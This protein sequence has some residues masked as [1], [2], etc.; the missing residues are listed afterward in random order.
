M[1]K[2]LLAP[3]KY[4][5]GTAILSDAYRY[6]AHIGRNFVII[7]D[8][9]VTDI[10][11]NR[12]NTGFKN[13]GS[14]CRFMRFNGESTL[15]EVKRLASKVS[16]EEGCDGIIGAGGGKTLD[17]AKLVGNMCGLPVVSVPT[18]ASNDSACSC[19]ASIY[20]ESGSFQ[21]IERV[22]ENP[23]VVL[24][25]TEIISKAPMRFFIAGMGEAFSTYYSARACYRSGVPNYTGGERTYT[26]LSISKTCRDVL[27]R[28]GVQALEDMKA[29]RISE[30]IER[31]I[32][33]NIYLSGVGY[34]NNGCAASHAVHNALTIA[35][36]PFGS[37]HGEGTA[38]GVLVQLIM[39]YYEVGQWDHDEWNCIINFYRDIGLP[40]NYAHLKIAEP[41][42]AF[43]SRV[44]EAACLKNSNIHNMPFKV[45]EKKVY[46]ALKTL[47]DMDID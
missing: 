18:I 29:R 5:Q 11:S 1:V 13:A 22:K 42:G 21:K 17:T 30:P 31:I 40:R 12:I 7:A 35:V 28:Y 19:M 38:F 8:D 26:A 4:Y 2:S 20:S 23:K 41:D 34:E 9:K 47:R 46:D 24:V 37:M 10:I 45:T 16:N 44:A 25:D 15:K 27:L 33:A 6:V 3:A 43:L 39:E 14:E 36:N 32:E